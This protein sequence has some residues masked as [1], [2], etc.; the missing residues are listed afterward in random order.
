M[1]VLS[2]SSDEKVFEKGS[3]VRVRQESYAKHFDALDI[4]LP[5]QRYSSSTND[6][7]LTI[8]PAFT[9]TLFFKSFWSR[10]W[11]PI[12]VSGVIRKTRPDV[13]TVQDPFELGLL[14]FIGMWGYKIP[15]HVQVHTDFLSSEFARHSLLNRLRALIARFVLRRA[16]RIRVILERTKD[17]IYA[18]GISVPISVLPIFVD[19][20]RFARVPRTKHSRFKIALLSIGRLEPEKKFSRAIDALRSAREAGHD[21]GLT[22][23]GSG[24]E[25][26]R[27][28]DYARRHGLEHF[29]EFTGAQ[30]D[31]TPHLSTADTL[32]VTSDYEGY[33]RTLL[34]AALARIPIITTDVGIVGEVLIPDESALVCPVGDTECLANRIERLVVDNGLRAEMVLHARAV[35]EAHQGIFGDLPR[36]I[37][38]NISATAGV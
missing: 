8:Y 14:T 16:A 24:S 21:A 29:V 37:A 38:E 33:G 20:E 9:R 23:V 30:R 10:L 4:V 3:T 36:R 1:R 27:L 32:L 2:V 26:K 35:A 17:D 13:V 12:A 34:Q 25:E 31:V 6:G 15:L 19:T 28:R 22:I 7:N 5:T 11:I 18:R